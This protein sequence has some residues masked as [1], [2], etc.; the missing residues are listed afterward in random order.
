MR[1]ELAKIMQPTAFDSKTLRYYVEV[2]PAYAASGRDGQSRFL[3]RFM[4]LLQP[5][6][7]VLDLGCGGAIDA[8]ALQER[9]FVVEAIEASPSL[10]KQAADRLG[11]AVRVMRF[12]EL[13]D[14][15]TYDAVWASASLIHVPR[16]ALSDVLSKIHTALKPGGVHFATYKSGDSEGRDSV[17]RYYNYPSATELRQFYK[18]SAPWDVRSITEYVGGGFEG[19]NGPW[20]AIQACRSVLFT[21]ASA[22]AE[23]FD[24]L[25]RL[26][27]A[28]MQQSLERIGRYDERRAFERFRSTFTPEHT[29][30]VLVAGELAGCVAVTPEEGGLVLEHFYLYPAF[31]GRGLGTA[32]LR[33][34]LA[35]AD[36]A[37][38]SVRLS[39]LR[40][41]DAERFYRRFGFI[42][43]AQ[44]DFDIYLARLPTQTCSPASE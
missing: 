24:R 20:I 12:D 30:L 5:G 11:N 3:Q 28:A 29:R 35:E 31:Q 21:F 18:T 9:G 23:D 10:A 19:G 4:N 7:K 44:D 25:L 6:S 16:I 2:A 27:I 15:E 26:R 38:Q 14:I 22:T 41:S 17:G 1:R 37:G 36:K 13:N 32:I 8:A 34:V 33:H 42:E 43:T 39:V 40:M